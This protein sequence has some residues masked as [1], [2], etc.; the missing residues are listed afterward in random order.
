MRS[1]KK[2]SNWYEIKGT[3]SILVREY[4]LDNLTSACT[5]ECMGYFFCQCVSSMFV[6]ISPQSRHNQQV[7]MG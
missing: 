1:E 3:Y 5:V 4:I 6:Q 7:V 2:F